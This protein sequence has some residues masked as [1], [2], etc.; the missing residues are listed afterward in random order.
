MRINENIASF[1]EAIIDRINN[2][3]ARAD[4]A[5]ARN[6]RVLAGRAR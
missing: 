2:P 3:E 1:Y 5:G 6:D 4:A